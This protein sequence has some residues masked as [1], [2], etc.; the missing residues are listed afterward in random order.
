LLL[1]LDPKEKEYHDKMIKY[2]ENVKSTYNILAIIDSAE[3]FKAMLERARDNRLL[4]E[5]AYILKVERKIA[6][7]ILR[8][9]KQIKNGLSQ[10]LTQKLREK[11]F[12]VLKT[13]AQDII[14]AN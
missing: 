4:I 9:N 5:K 13:F 8:A 1:F 14:T 6:D 7:V 3:Q 10:G 2:Y 12:Q 11:E